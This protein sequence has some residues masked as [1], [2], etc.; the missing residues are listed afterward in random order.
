[1]TEMQE[2]QSNGNA[3]Y[4][5]QKSL[6]VV[7]DHGDQSWSHQNGSLQGQIRRWN[8]CNTGRAIHPEP[9]EQRVGPPATADV[10]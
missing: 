10:R 8:H 1:M 3:T 6:S 4:T 7:C 9:W 5:Q 2:Y